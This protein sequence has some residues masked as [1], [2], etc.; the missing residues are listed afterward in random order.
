LQVTDK[1][2]HIMLY[3]LSWSRFELTTPMVRGTDCIGSCKS[4][5]HTMTAFLF[6]WPDI[7]YH[8]MLCRLHLVMNGVRTHNIRGDMHWLHKSNYHTI[9]TTTAPNQVDS[10]V[11][12]LVLIEIRTHN[13]NGERHWLHR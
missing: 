8:I 11:V 1:L 12:H 7:L 2:Y 13:T 9:T 3:T 5:N 4:N 10:L 6:I